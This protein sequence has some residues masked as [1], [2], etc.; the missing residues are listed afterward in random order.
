M[1]WLR[2]IGPLEDDEYG[3][4]ERLDD[5]LEDDLQQPNF[6]LTT[7]GRSQLEGI[8][9][10]ERA[11]Q[12]CQ[13]AGY[14]EEANNL[15]TDVADLRRHYE[16]RRNTHEKQLLEVI[17]RTKTPEERAAIEAEHQEFLRH[18]LKD[19]KLERR[20]VRGKQD[21]RDDG[22]YDHLQHPSGKEKTWRLFVRPPREGESIK[23]SYGIENPIFEDAP[24]PGMIEYLVVADSLKKARLLVK[25]GLESKSNV[26]P[27]IRSRRPL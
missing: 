6:D 16:E 22:Q 19:A 3:P 27:G 21:G 5:A 13:E 14:L 15:R 26:V 11:A 10:L 17:F 7:E 8:S 20:R 18:L 9:E 25:L 4:D 24:A 1:G 2:G 23:A 12:D